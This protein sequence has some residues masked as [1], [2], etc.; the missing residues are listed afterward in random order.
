MGADHEVPMSENEINDYFE[1]D[2]ARAIF[3]AGE[4][5]SNRF[6]LELRESRITAEHGLRRSID[7]DSWDT[8]DR[9]E[10]LFEG[11]EA[12]FNEQLGVYYFLF[13]FFLSRLIYLL[14]AEGRVSEP[15]GPSVNQNGEWAP[16]ANKAV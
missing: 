16:Y 10:A 7:D 14:P 6:D 1:D 2:G 8:E 9:P 11:L 12:A 4:D 15:D 13:S 3:T 5:S